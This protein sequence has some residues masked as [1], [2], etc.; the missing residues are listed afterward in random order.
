MEI[1]VLVLA[2][3]AD[4]TT[5]QAMEILISHILFTQINHKNLIFD[6]K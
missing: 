6:I 5:N 1:W 3:V 4:A 2:A